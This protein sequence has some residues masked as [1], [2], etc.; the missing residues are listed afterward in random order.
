[1][2]G[3]AIFKA[4]MDAE[5]VIR[6]LRRM[7]NENARLNESLTKLKVGSL[8]A[9]QALTINYRQLTKVA[10]EFGQIGAAETARYRAEVSQLKEWF[11]MAALTQ[12]QYKKG[13]EAANESHRQRVAI[14]RTE[15]AEQSR[16]KDL[17]KQVLSDQM[18]AVEKTKLKVDDLTKAWRAGYLTTEQYKQSVK[19]AEANTSKLPGPLAAA[20][21]EI[22]GMVAG[23]AASFFSVRGI[24][25]GIK[26]ARE[27]AKREREEARRAQ[28]TVAETQAEA[29]KMLG[30]VSTQEASGFLTRVGEIGAK[31]GMGDEQGLKALYQAAA[32]TLSSTGSNAQLTGTILA[33]LIPLSKSKPDQLAPLAGAVA[34]LA[35]ILKAESPE[36]IKRVVGMVLTTT[37]QARITN[38]GAFKEAAAAIAGATAVDQGQ[39]RNRAAREAG[40][41]FAAIGGSIKDPE[42]G[43]TKTAT[44]ELAVALSRLLPEKDVQRAISDEEKGQLT[45]Q[46]DK[47]KERIQGLKEGKR[48]PDQDAIDELQ[49]I[50]KRQAELEATLAPKSGAKLKKKEREG[51]QSELASLNKRRET[52][53]AREGSPQEASAAIAAL[54]SELAEVEQGLQTGV[55][56]QKGTGLQTFDQRLRAVQKD[57]QLQL[58]FWEKQVTGK[59]PTFRGAIA[60]VVRQLLEDSGSEISKRYDEANKLISD[61]PQA[62]TQI[63]Q[64][65]Q[66]ASPQLQLTELNK[67][68]L[69]AQ[70]IMKQRN[71]SGARRDEVETAFDAAMKL[72]R[73]GSVSDYSNDLLQGTAESLKNTIFRPDTERRIKQLTEGLQSRRERIFANYPSGGKMSTEDTDRIELLDKTLANM[74]VALQQE[75]YERAAEATGKQQR[76]HLAPKSSIPATELPAE[77]V[78]SPRDR[79]TRNVATQPTAGNEIPRPPAVDRLRAAN[80]AFAADGMPITPPGTAGT[81]TPTPATPDPQQAELIRLQQETNAKLDKIAASNSQ[82]AQQQPSPVGVTAATAAGVN[83][84][85]LS[86]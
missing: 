72:T 85:T 21:S 76:H 77:V 26:A 50:D 70:G 51:L 42:G 62:Y 81:G 17:A 73:D 79:G 47:L 3:E 71:T 68:N 49:A 45:G 22:V 30:P 43:L 78:A 34:D 66:T 24:V 28:L 15:A 11:G 58:R 10:Q 64:N 31:N 18:T 56:I 86:R 48:S 1:M 52:L 54:E 55:S 83:S 65:L 38:L 84:Q 6:E 61:D 53:A 59:K 33:A 14:L 82:M 20:K 25:E 9:N 41:A 19:D 67:S 32:D 4:T 29:V 23:F 16:L 46:R 12:E 35:G 69:S 36:E 75:R 39:D 44:A 57:R 8:E 27:E 80:A 7:Q 37:G 63:V 13:V 2:S 60:P 40:A 74:A 5:D